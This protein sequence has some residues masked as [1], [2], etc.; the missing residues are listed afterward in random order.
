M[1]PDGS[2]GIGLLYEHREAIV[3][4]SSDTRS[5][6]ASL[7]GLAFATAEG[8]AKLDFEPERLSY[9]LRVDYGTTEAVVTPVPAHK[10]ATATVAGVAVALRVGET[11]VPVVVTAEDGSTRSYDI[12]VTRRQRPPQ[13]SVREDGF[14]LLPVHRPRRE[15]RHLPAGEH[16]RP[17]DAFPGD[18]HR[19]QFPGRES[20]PGLAQPVDGDLRSACGLC[21]RAGRRGRP[22]N[23]AG[24]AAAGAT[25]DVDLSITADEIDNDGEVFHVG[26]A[27]GGY[28][29]RRA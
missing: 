7:S 12:R 4:L 1:A 10:R 16:Q 29:H 15:G 19:A 24:E 11:V 18:R 26:L 20:R 2:R 17:G 28:T 23:W 3:I 21:R 8:P 5:A 6:D 13:V 9:T 14:V 22:M 27:P 25:K